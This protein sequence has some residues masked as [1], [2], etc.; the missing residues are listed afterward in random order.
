MKLAKVAEEPENP[1]DKPSTEEPV[2]GGNN[3]EEEIENPQTGDNLFAYIVTGVIAIVALGVVLK[4]KKF[5]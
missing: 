2:Q 1:T 3:S 4:I 5:N